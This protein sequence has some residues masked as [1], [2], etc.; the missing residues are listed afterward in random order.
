MKKVF[1]SVVLAATL[2]LSSCIGSFGL[3]KKVYNWNNSVG[4]KWV[5]ELVFLVFGIVPVYEIAIFVDV[6]VLNTIEFWTGNHPVAANTEVIETENGQYVV[7]TNQNGY[8]ITKGDETVQFVNENDVWFVKKGETSIPMFT[9]TDDNHVCL[10]LGE[11]SAIVE[12][13]QAGIDNLGISIAK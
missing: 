2:F 10:N 7:E 11:T 4:S 8:T 1:L 9:Y 3:T 5:N 12:L 6:V 13:S